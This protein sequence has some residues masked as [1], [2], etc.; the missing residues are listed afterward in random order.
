MLTLFFHLFKGI[1]GKM[2]FGMFTLSQFITARSLDTSTM[3]YNTDLLYLGKINNCV[4]NTG[5]SVIFNLYI[6]SK[7]VLIS[8]R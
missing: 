2:E 5:F 7:H 1:F 3:Q 8:D 6:T 4:F